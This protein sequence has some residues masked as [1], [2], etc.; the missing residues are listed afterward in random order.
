MPDPQTIARED[1]ALFV[2]ACFVGTGQ[3]E[4]YS[5][6]NDQVLS[7]AFLHEYICGNYRRLYA[8]S[9]AVG[10]NHLN[11]LEIVRRLLISGRHCPPGFRL[12]E[13]R[14]IRASLQHLPPQRVWKLFERLRDDGVNNRR[15]R[16]TIRQYIRGHK[17][18][19]FQAVK[20]RHKVR[21]SV[22][23]AHLH[24]NGELPAFLF[25]AKPRFETPLFEAYRAA[26]YSAEAIY[27]LP[28]SVAQGFAV[29]HNVPQGVFLKRIQPR[30]TERERLRLQRSSQG[31]VQLD[32]EKL[33]LSEFCAYLLRL[34]LQ[35]RF[36]RR[37]ELQSWLES[38]TNQS[39]GLLEHLPLQGRVAAVLDNSFSSSGSSQK[40]NRPL[41][42][43]WAVHRLLSAS[44]G[45]HYRAFWTTPLA[46]ELLL[47]AKGQTNLAER[48]LDA[49]E[50]GAQTVIVVSDGVENA[51]SGAF[52]A[53]LEGYLRIGGQ[54][55]V[56]HFNPVFDPE[57]LQVARLHPQ[58]PALGLRSSDDLPALLGFAQFLSNEATFE[59]LE[60]YL[61]ARAQR[62][63]NTIPSQEVLE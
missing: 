21:S 61:E 44:M 7:L 40:R 60:S 6:R 56:L 20:Y 3:Q 32:P 30:L 5:A 49:L 19:V 4:F 63:L 59:D 37:T 55:R 45:S 18:M 42:L 57:T 51:P 28:F 39:V 13:G 62:L 41:V 53:I 8:R 38:A 22:L 1:L 31:R 36:E 50:W 48:L 16:A 11:R 23:H 35:E 25:E 27:E 2:N 12:E 43:A 10:I 33:P 58:L 52:K 26:Q 15:T 24:L 17:D 14:L 9:L 54:A 29:K 34:P 47:H 46:D